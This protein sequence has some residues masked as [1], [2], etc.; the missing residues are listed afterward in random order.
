IEADAQRRDPGP[1]TL[2]LLEPG[3]PVS[4]LARVSHDRRQ[5][6][7]PAL[8]DDPAV[9]Q[10]QRGLVDERRLE[11]RAQGLEV[12]EVRHRGGDQRRLDPPAGLPDPAERLE[13][14]PEADEVARVGLAERGPARE[15]L[16]VAHRAQEGAKPGAPGGLVYQRGDR[17]LSRGDSRG[18]EKRPEQPLAQEP[19]AHRRPCLVAPAASSRAR[20]ALSSRVAPGTRIS[21]G[22]RSS[23]AESTASSRA[24]S[25]PT[26]N[27]PVDTSSSATPLASRP[28]TT[29]RRKLFA[30]PAR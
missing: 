8:A 13:A 22:R 19:G 1:G 26:Q 15:P 10:R 24:P 29:A 4:R 5:R 14:R 9:V 21:A 3:D 23:A 27:S 17:D 18:I 7:I 2:T 12:G 6:V 11:E 30:A 20:S 16:E 25:S 28:R